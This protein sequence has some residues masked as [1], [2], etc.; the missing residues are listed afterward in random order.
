GGAGSATAGSA[1]VLSTSINIT[2]ATGSGAQALTTNVVS[3]NAATANAST[4]TVGGYSAAAVDLST[5]GVKTATLSDGTDTFTVEFQVTAAFSDTDTMD[6]D[7]NGLGAMVFADA[8]TSSTTSVTFTVGTGTESA[9]D[10][11][12]FSIDAITQTALG[13][14]GT[15]LTGATV[16]NSETA[17]DAVN[18]AIDTLNTS[19]A[20]I[21]AAQNRLG[22][23]SAN[24]A[25]TIENQEASRSTLLDLDVA[26]EMS[27]FTS[28][29]VLMQAGISMMAQ[30]NQIPQ[31]LMQLF[32]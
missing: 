32:Q 25:T 12:T 1:A 7:V 11:V 26:S 27:S 18:A 14:N 23:A 30:A 31:N 17:L 5:T 22:F 13:I 16:T 24:L 21:G 3:I 10:D 19:R 9:E 6:L 28:K 15:S 4:L 2:A 29:Q 20:T 8:Q